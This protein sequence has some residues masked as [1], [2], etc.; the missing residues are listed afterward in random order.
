MTRDNI[1]RIGRD[2]ELFNTIILEDITNLLLDYCVEKG[3][4]INLSIKFIT[5]IVTSTFVIHYVKVALE[6]YYIKYN[7]IKLYSLPNLNGV[8]TRK[9]IS[10]F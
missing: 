7:I 1:V 3:K 8:N 4:D 9:L 5:H 6:Y 2:I 10:I